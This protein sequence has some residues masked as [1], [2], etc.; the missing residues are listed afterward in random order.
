MAIEIKMTGQIW[1]VIVKLIVG[2]YVAL[3]TFVIIGDIY[4]FEGS[5]I[6]K[7]RCPKGFKI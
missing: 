6:Q 4:V 5:S 7:L 2:K 3:E 1:L